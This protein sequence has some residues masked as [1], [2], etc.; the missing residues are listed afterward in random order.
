LLGY[1]D[2]HPF[3]NHITFAR[4]KYIANEADKKKIIEAL[5]KPVEKTDFLVDDFK[6]Y[7]SD[8]TPEG[9]VYELVQEFGSD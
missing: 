5:K 6:L 2:D 1:K 3:K 8:L 7:K 4:I 9:P